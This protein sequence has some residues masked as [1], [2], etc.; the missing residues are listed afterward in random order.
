FIRLR[1]EDL[2]DLSHPNVKT[3]LKVRN[4]KGYWSG[5]LIAI[6]KNGDKIPVHVSNVI[7]ED[8]IH[9]GNTLSVF[10]VRDRR[11]E[12]KIEKERSF[13]TS[14]SQ[15]LLSDNSFA[16]SLHQL[17]VIVNQYFGISL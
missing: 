13:I 9:K 16:Q 11:E 7:F 8:A 1:R 14:I 2:L 10:T 3:W 17:L 4:E 6:N 15:S 12:M 5:N